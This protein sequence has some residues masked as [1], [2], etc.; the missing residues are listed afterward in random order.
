MYKKKT[1]SALSLLALSLAAATSVVGAEGP[2][3]FIKEIPVGGAGGWDYLAVDSAAQRLYVSHATKVVVI[4][5]AK[6]QVVGEIADT[7]GVHGIAI[8]PDLGRCFVSNGREAKVSIVDSKTLKT[9]KKVDTGENPDAILYEPAHKEVYAFNGRSHS[10]TVI[11]AE[12]GEV[13]ATVDLQGKPE[14]AIC[15]PEAGR[16]Y[17]NLEDKSAVAVLDTATH[18][19]VATWSLA[20]GQAPSGMAYDAKNHRLFCGCAD[21]KMVVM[22]DSTN[23]KVITNVPIGA[24]VDAN[25]FD[26]ATKFVFSSNGEGNVT[27]AHEDSPDKLTVVQTLSTEKGAKTMIL[28]PQTHKIYLGAAKFQTG[29]SQKRPAP[30]PG[31]FRILVYGMEKANP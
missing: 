11:G 27:I 13:V 17:N 26:P 8:A 12:S 19:V 30:V 7:P 14:F 18:K 24:D 29:G 22:M 4:D 31:S 1:S 21:N 10:A 15:D 9:I 2:Y 25:C 6:D 16:I 5:L 23:G 3:R 28:D 20:P